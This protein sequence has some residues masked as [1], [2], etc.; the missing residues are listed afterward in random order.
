MEIQEAQQNVKTKLKTSGVF[1][2]KLLCL[3]PVKM[4]RV[5]SNRPA[6]HA[7]A[8]R[9]DLSRC[10]KRNYSKQGA[11][12]QHSKNHTDARLQAAGESA[13]TAAQPVVYRSR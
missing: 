8:A 5:S 2:M 13:P 7:D 11:R 1:A 6:A 12:L 10:L 9:A 3:P 4:T